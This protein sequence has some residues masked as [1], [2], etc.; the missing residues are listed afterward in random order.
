M[1]VSIPSH[2][3][4]EITLQHLKS[5]IDDISLDI[6]RLKKR[7]RECHSYAKESFKEDIKRQKQVRKAAKIL[8][9][10]FMTPDEYDSYI[11]SLDM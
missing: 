7:K 8:L 10:Y 2:L 4:D 6:I 11:E 3:A 5:V 1:V 9:S